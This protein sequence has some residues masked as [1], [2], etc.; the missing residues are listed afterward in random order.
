MPIYEYRCVNCGHIFDKFQSIGAD[1]S[2]VECPK[3]GTPRPER[4]FSAFASSGSGA[5]NTSSGSSGSCGS[6]GFS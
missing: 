5:G 6:G 3:C 4:L 2:S 1:N